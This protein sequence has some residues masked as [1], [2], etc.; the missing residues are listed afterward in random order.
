MVVTPSMVIETSLT[1]DLAEPPPPEPELSPADCADDV[2]EVDDVADVEDVAAVDDVAVDE[3]V[4][5]DGD[6]VT[7]ALVEAI[8]LTDMETRSR[9]S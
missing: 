2:A 5:V 8:A 4:A 7:A 9:Q 1:T 6:V 3:F